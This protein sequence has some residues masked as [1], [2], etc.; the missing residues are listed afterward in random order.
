MVYRTFIGPTSQAAQGIL[1][2]AKNARRQKTSEVQ[3]FDQ[4]DRLL[5]MNKEAIE[6]VACL[7]RLVCSW[8]IVNE[9]AKHFS[10]T[11]G[12]VITSI[13]MMTAP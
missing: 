11:N 8:M 5:Q 7:V 12:K 2:P 13:T 9:T 3:D 6:V 4:D 1:H 10:I